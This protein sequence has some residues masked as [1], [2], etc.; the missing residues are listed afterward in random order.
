MD[1]GLRVR[2]RRTGRRGVIA[3]LI[4]PPRGGRSLYVVWGRSLDFSLM[5]PDEIEPDPETPP[6]T[7]GGSAAEPDWRTLLIDSDLDRTRDPG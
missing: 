3:E 1:P 2:C 5:A 6:G 4:D 7:E